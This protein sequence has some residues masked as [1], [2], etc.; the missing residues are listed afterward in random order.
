MLNLNTKPRTL[1]FLSGR[2][3]IIL[4]FIEQETTAPSCSCTV[5]HSLFFWSPSF[6]LR[7]LSHAHPLPEEIGTRIANCIETARAIT[8]NIQDMRKVLANATCQISF[9]AGGEFLLWTPVGVPGLCEKL[10]SQVSQPVNDASQNIC[11]KL[12]RCSC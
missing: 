9:R 12:T 1:Y 11:S 7:L 3:L 5:V 4:L 2:L 6:S 8:A 10:L